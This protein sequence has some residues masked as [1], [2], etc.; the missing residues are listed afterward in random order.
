[1]RRV[2]ASAFMVGCLAAPALARAAEPTGGEPVMWGIGVVTLAAAVV[3]LVIALGLARVAEGSAMAENISYVVVACVCLAGSV[4]ATWAARFVPEGPV[5]V[6]VVIGGQALVIVAIACF[7]VYFFQVRAALKRFLTAVSGQ[8]ALARAH[9][10]ESGADSEGGPEDGAGE[11]V[12][13]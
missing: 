9:M 1:M 8:D 7:C 4:L 2:F 13:A 12:D 10:P 3:L 6:Q 5:A 11:H